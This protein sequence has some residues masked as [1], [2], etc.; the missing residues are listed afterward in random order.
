MSTTIS[1]GESKP[2]EYTLWTEA[3]NIYVRQSSGL[4]FDVN[5]NL[6]VGFNVNVSNGARRHKM[7]P[8]L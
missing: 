7:S 1:D 6:K 2:H 8:R 3:N 5:L 4:T